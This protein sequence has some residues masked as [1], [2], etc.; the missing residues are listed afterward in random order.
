MQ[1]FM[2]QHGPEINTEMCRSCYY[3]DSCLRFVGKRY[4]HFSL[5]PLP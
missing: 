5:K 4:E 1:V 3:I 2:V